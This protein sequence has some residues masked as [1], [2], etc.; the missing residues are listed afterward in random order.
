MDLPHNILQPYKQLK[1]NTN[2]EGEL[3]VAYETFYYSLE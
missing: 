2:R 1:K 3:N